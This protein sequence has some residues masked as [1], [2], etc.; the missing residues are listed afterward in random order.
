MWSVLSPKKFGVRRIPKLGTGGLKNLIDQVE[1]KLFID[2]K[3]KYFIGSKGC[4][5]ALKAQIRNLCSKI[6]VVV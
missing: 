5:S 2:E 3:N 1:Q 4:K 6:S